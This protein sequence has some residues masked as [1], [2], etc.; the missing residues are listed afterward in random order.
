MKE[1]V[2]IRFRLLWGA[3]HQFYLFRYDCTSTS[4]DEDTA[5]KNYEDTSLHDFTNI[6]HQSVST[7][8]LADT[9]A[10]QDWESG[11]SFSAEHGMIWYDTHPR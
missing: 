8:L 2:S 4:R 5:N 1:G 9:A 6:F 3:A 10:K 7:I 11:I